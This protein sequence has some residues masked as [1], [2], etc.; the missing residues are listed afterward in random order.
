[1]NIMIGSLLDVR[2]FA[3]SSR[4]V[5]KTSSD[6]GLS[7]EGCENGLGNRFYDIPCSSICIKTMKGT[8]WIQ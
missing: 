1:M 4:F 5:M 6:F 2:M 7:T 8:N 3:K